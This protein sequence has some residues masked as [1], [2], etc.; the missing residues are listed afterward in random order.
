MGKPVERDQWG[1]C[2][3]CHGY[4]LRDVISKGEVVTVFSPLAD[5]EFLLL[6]DG[7]QMKISICKPCKE[8]LT[9]K[10]YPRLM[11]AAIKGWDWETDYLVRTDSY[12][13]WDKKKKKTYMAKQRKLKIVTQTKGLSKTEITKR[14]KKFKSK[15]K[16]AK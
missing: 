9:E 11:E 10:D 5:E 4:L 15:K 1:H 2:I 6:N 16:V 14:V 7:S 13:D 3:K 8:A 12:V